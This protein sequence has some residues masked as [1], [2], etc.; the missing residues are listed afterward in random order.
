[1]NRLLPEIG[2]WYKEIQQGFI[3]EVV[4]YDEAADSI[5]TQYLDGAVSGF[6]M[7]AW[8][9]L[10]LDRVEEPED[11]RNGYEL[12]D[13]DGSDPDEPI[14]PENWSGVLSAIEPDFTAALD[15]F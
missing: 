10:T 15:D 5:E 13:E 2:C 9:E 7:D 11:W 8:R 6:D 1:M 14:R 3:F 4:A 12:S